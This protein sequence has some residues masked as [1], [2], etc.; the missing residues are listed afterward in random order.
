MTTRIAKAD[1]SSSAPLRVGL[2]VPSNNTTM[3]GELTAWLPAGSTVTTVK[4]PRGP[5][6]LTAETIPAYRDS[7]IALARRHFDKTKF[8]LIAYGCTAAGFIS[9]PAGDAELSKMLSDATGLP[10]VTTARAMVSALQHDRAK[11]VAVVTP[12]QD[13]VNAQLTAF[14]ADGGI[15]VVRLETFRAADVAALGRITAEEVRDLARATMGGDCDA[16]FIGCSQLPTHAILDDLARA[17][18]RPAW[19]S[20][21]ATAWDAVRVPVS[22]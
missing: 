13:S 22:A 12:Y 2:M 11:R 8:D 1:A 15:A 21:R 16:L 7:A 3:E 19:S 4:I 20:I 6:L 17:F 14:L 18:D 10:V 9:G 5:G